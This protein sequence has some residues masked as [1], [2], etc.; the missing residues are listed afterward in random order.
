MFSVDNRYIGDKSRP[1]AEAVLLELEA[2][3]GRLVRQWAQQLYVF[4]FTV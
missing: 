1:I 2:A 3:T 4:A